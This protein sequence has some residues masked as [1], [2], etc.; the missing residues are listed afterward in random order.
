MKKILFIS[1]ILLT[2]FACESSNNKAFLNKGSDTVYQGSLW[3]DKGAYVLSGL[4]R[5][6]MDTK[7]TI[8]TTQLGTYVVLY[9]LMYEN[10]LYTIK[11]HVQVVMDDRIEVYLNE[12]IDTIS[13]GD[14]WIDAGLESSYDISYVVLG[15]VDTSKVGV[16]RMEYVISYLGN[17]WIKVRYV[18]VL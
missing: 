14:T 2:L 9:E 5:I 11:R 1:I 10:V 8:S 17:Q 12:G 18:N 6:E 13:V 4:L 15:F 3:V 16:Y 7:D